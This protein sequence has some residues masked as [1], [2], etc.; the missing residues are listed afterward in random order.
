[1]G[2]IAV[3][4][5][6]FWATHIPAGVSQYFIPIRQIS[7]FTLNGYKQVDGYRLFDQDINTRFSDNWSSDWRS[8]DIYPLDV[9]VVFDSI[10]NIS[11]TSYY[12]NYTNGTTYSL[13]YYDKD[14]RQIGDSAI[15]K[16]YGGGWETIMAGGKM[17]DSFASKLIVHWLQMMAYGISGLKDVL[18]A[19]LRRFFRPLLR[20]GPLIGE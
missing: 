20:A 7:V 12:L 8:G 3:F 17:S 18:W 2:K 1:M 6:L 11:K 9:W 4:V 15:I 5:V 19:L 16:V 10:Y 14:R 13:F